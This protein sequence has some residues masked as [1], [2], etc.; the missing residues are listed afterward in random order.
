MVATMSSLIRPFNLGGLPAINV[1]IALP[2][3][4]LKT[5]LQVVDR[6]GADELVC[7]IARLFERAELAR[8]M[9]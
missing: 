6:H 8:A 9:R 4:A 1:P 7:S 3:S 2:G 5:G